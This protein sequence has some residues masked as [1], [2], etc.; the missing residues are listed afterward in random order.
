MKKVLTAALITIACLSAQAQES[1]WRIFAGVGYADGGETIASGTITNEKTKSVLP[2]QI[3]SGTGFQQRIGAEY[4]L[5]PQFTL[6]GSIGHSA[7]SPM[8]YD[9]SIDF[10]VVPVEIMGFLETGSGFRLG[11]GLRQSN[12]ELRGTGKAADV[13]LNGSSAGKPGTVVEIQYLFQ[14]GPSRANK[15]VPQFGLTLRGVNEVFSTAWG[16]LK[17]DNY[18][19]GVVLYY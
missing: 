19:L 14:N 9:G 2:F 4:R 10:T 15:S 7:N 5:S 11:A 18:E 12:A 3:K 8:G 16:D 6:Q 13:A 1:N 17:G